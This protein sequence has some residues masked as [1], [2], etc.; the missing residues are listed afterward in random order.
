M[1]YFFSTDTLSKVLDRCLHLSWGISHATYSTAIAVT[2]LYW[3]L[4]FKDKE[5]TYSNVYV[6]AVQVRGVL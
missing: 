1:V 5:N 3:T 2:A 6:H 4:L